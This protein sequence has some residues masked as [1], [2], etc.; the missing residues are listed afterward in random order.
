MNVVVRT[1]D[2]ISRLPARLSGK[3]S[4][5]T[6]AQAAVVPQSKG[7]GPPPAAR[8]ALAA[9]PPREA[10]VYAADVITA[11]NGFQVTTA[12]KFEGRCPERPPLSGGGGG[13]MDGGMF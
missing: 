10:V 3:T 9:R 11:F 12:E 2:G 1:R 5:F 13:A 4:S 6:L 8:A 7:Y